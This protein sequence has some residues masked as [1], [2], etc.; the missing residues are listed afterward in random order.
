MESAPVQ[1]GYTKSQIN[2]RITLNQC[3]KAFWIIVIVRFEIETEKKGQNICV[4]GFTP[5]I[6]ISVELDPYE[7]ASRGDGQ[8]VNLTL[9]QQRRKT[10]L[11]NP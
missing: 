4:V 2:Y 9:G 8:L 7:G 11:R 10:L 6:L 3:H 5:S 1:S